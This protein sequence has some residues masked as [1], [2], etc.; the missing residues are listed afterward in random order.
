MLHVRAGVLFVPGR[1]AHERLDLQLQPL[2]GAAR[3]L[4]VVGHQQKRVRVVRRGLGA[5][6]APEH[7]RTL[8][9]AEHP[10]LR[11]RVREEAEHGP[12]AMHLF[13]MVVVVVVV[14]AVSAVVVVVLA[15]VVVLS[16]AAAAAVEGR[17]GVMY[18]GP[19]THPPTQ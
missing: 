6:D 12:S 1:D 13:F 3:A 16:A 4:V 7:A 8:Q 18:E 15:V 2:L 14:V 5:E 10:R 19:P 17:G 9:R 11:H